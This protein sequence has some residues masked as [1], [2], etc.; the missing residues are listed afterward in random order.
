MGRTIVGSLVLLAAWG[1]LVQAQTPPP[2]NLVTPVPDAAGVA[3]IPTFV[4]NA[5]AGATSYELQVAT[6]PLFTELVIDTTG[7]SDTTLTPS[8]PLDPATT[9]RWRVRAVDTAGVSAWAPSDEGAAFTTVP[10][11][12]PPPML[13][14]PINDTTGLKTLPVLKWDAVAGADVYAL[15]LATDSLFVSIVHAESM[16]TVT[17]F[18]PPVPLAIGTTYSWRVRASNAG[19]PGPWSDVWHFTTYPSVPPGPVLSLPP[20]A[21]T[22]VTVLPEFFW[23]PAPGT[24][25]Y[26][27][28]LATDTLFSVGLVE[29]AGVADTTMTAS[30]TLDSAMRYFWR[31]RGVNGGGDGEWSLPRSFTTAGDPPVAPVLLTPADSAVDIWP[32]TVFTWEPVSR[33]AGYRLQIATDT[34]FALIVRDTAGV[35]EL[36]A[37]V[38]G[39]ARNTHHYWRV[40]AANAVGTGPWSARWRFLTVPEVPPA[41]G[42][43]YPAAGAVEVPNPPSFLW[44]TAERSVSYEIQVAF[45]TDFEDDSLIIYE[46]GLTDTSFTPSFIMDGGTEYNWRIRGVNAGGPG[47]WSAGRQFT[48]KLEAPFAVPLYSPENGATDRLTLVILGWWATTDNPADSY[49]LQVSP[50]SLFGRLTVDAAGLTGTERLVTGL[51][52]SETYYW[53]VN[54]VNRVGTGPWSEVW[55]FSTRAGAPRPPILST[56]PDSATE[57]PLMPTFTWIPGGG[58]DTYQL[59]VAL[60]SAFTSPL[61]DATG[62]TDTTYTPS[63]PLGGATLHYW[64]MRAVNARG[65]S[66]WTGVRSF[67]TLL[68][69]PDATVA[70]PADS[71]TSTGFR[72]RWMAVPAAL[73]YGIDVGPDSLFA[74]FVPGYE[75]AT[76]TDTS[77]AVTGLV[78]GTTYYYRVRA[79]H[80]GGTGPAS[81]VVRVTTAGVVVALRAILAGPWTGD[82]MSTALWAQGI[83][84]LAQPYGAAPWSYAGSEQVDSIP[85]R[86]VDWVL[87][88]ARSDTVTVVERRAAFLLADGTVTDLDGSSPV[89]MPALTAGSY[90]I[91]LRHRNHLAAMSALPVALDATG[92]LHDLTAGAVRFY[93]GDANDLG[94][95]RCGLIPG[96]PDANGGIGATDLASIRVAVGGLHVYVATDVDMNGGI[97]A[98]DLA[99]PRSLIGRMCH[100]P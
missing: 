13:T 10:P 29:S 94:G 60:T 91:V 17:T 26:T 82:S 68:P 98:T 46:T 97:G 27:M 38:S 14:A 43:V 74:S 7:L 6:G 55:H 79:T 5:A 71:I 96:D 83:I 8:R 45:R 100:V 31:V 48:T 32:D 51:A 63:A 20:D 78:S 73:T 22:G 35:S 2:P 44:M 40:Q 59:Q 12:P 52:N 4:W 65:N 92:D 3:L 1:S 67:T 54:A 11:V 90:Y 81:N 57:L 93:G 34:S 80:A 19:G 21:A 33:A 30:A 88:E 56:P 89:A 99:I 87:L 16:M 23:H 62:I 28:Q 64:R 85:E 39:L 50:D 18:T 25:S 75:N 37:R 70:L 41:P 66:S 84:P 95:G 76:M 53:R 42:L 61:I 47:A 77:C 49:H 9:Y 72:A 24:D 58:E 36:A 15:E 69:P 86:V